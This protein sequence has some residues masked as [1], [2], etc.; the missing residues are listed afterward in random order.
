[1]SDFQE[2]KNSDLMENKISFKEF[3]KWKKTEYYTNKEDSYFESYK[4]YK[5]F[6]EK[7]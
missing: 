2:Y 7:L 6:G 3:L 1:M 4:I 5:L